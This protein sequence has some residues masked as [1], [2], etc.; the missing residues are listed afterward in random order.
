MSQSSFRPRATGPA[1]FTLVELLV[2]IGIIALLISILLPSLNRARESAKSVVCL[3]NLRQI[4]TGLVLYTNGFNGS[5]PYGYWN[6]DSAFGDVYNADQANDWSNLLLQYLDSTAGGDSYIDNG[7]KG[8]SNV[9]EALH[10][11]SANAGDALTQYGVHPRLMPALSENDQASPGKKLRPYKLGTIKDSAETLLV[12]DGSLEP[13]SGD[14]QSTWGTT[15]TMYRLDWLESNGFYGLGSK[16]FML[17]GIADTM[18]GFFDRN[19]AGGTNED[20]A[21]NQG[22]ISFRHGS[23][24]PKDYKSVVCNILWADSH[25]SAQ[26]AA[27]ALAADPTMLDTGLSRRAVLLN[28]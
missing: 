11:P 9:R 27:G 28:R 5:L 15:A 6:G 2:V 14:G 22:N 26:R 21:A 3:S 12:A 25:A 16:P 8:P 13:V 10:C 4:G 1:G 20:N 24:N 17:E 19:V 7:I 18:T 23:G